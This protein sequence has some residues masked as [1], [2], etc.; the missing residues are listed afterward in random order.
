[1]QVKRNCAA[2]RLE[3]GGGRWG[4]KRKLDDFC[5]EN[6]YAEQLFIDQRGHHICKINLY[7]YK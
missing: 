6:T 1:M 7:I 3:L 2:M 5:D 4:G